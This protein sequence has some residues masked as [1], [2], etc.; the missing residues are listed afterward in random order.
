MI[1]LVAVD[2][3]W[4][5][6]LNGDLPWTIPGE[7][8]FFKEKTLGNTV[9]MGRK[10]LDSL[11]G[12]VPLK[13]RRNIILTRNPGFLCEGA[14][15]VKSPEELL[16]AIHGL[17][18]EKVFL[19]G[20]AQI[21]NLLLPYCNKAYVTKVNGSFKVDTHHPN[22]DIDSDWRITDISGETVSSNGIAYRRYVYENI[23]FCGK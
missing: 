1:S 8:T 18:P 4:G 7:L 3:N 23:Y 12:G 16:E 13:G 6:G 15:I 10:T 20:G 11:P 19:I 9:V 14:E 2:D 17:D 22:L 21:Y 5:I